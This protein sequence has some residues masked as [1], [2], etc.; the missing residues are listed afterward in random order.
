MNEITEHL[1]KAGI[2]DEEIENMKYFRPT[3]FHDCVERIV[4]PPKI[5][6]SGF[7]YASRSKVADNSLAYDSTD[8]STSLKCSLNAECS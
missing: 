6:Y 2:S 7:C 1:R 3:V 4:P 8:L 5:L